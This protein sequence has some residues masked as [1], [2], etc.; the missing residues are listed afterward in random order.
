MASW[1]SASRACSVSAVRLSEIALLP[2][3]ITSFPPAVL[4]VSVF[5]SA[6]VLLM[7]TMSFCDSHDVIAK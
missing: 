1:W 4:S 2:R 3:L 7:L 6:F 5:S